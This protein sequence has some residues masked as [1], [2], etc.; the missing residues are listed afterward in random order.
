MNT[1]EKQINVRVTA[2]M[3]DALKAKAATEYLDLSEIIRGLL[4]RWLKKA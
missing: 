1:K 2:K 3:M 4:I